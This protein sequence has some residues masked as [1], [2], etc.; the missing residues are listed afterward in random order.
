MD[1]DEISREIDEEG[2]EVDSCC[3]IYGL[4]LEYIRENSTIQIA[5]IEQIR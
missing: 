3:G 5:E 2:L 4:N 1:G